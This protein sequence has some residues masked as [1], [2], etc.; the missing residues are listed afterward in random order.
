MNISYSFF[1]VTI[2]GELNIV[3]THIVY[4]QKLSPA[5]IFRY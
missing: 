5:Y 4:R 2:S 1:D 3:N